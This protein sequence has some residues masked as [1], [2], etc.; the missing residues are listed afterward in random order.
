[1]AV[2]EA[3]KNFADN[4]SDESEFTVDDFINMCIYGYLTIAQKM[5]ARK[6][7]EITNDTIDHII[8]ELCI[9]ATINQEMFDWLRSIQHPMY[10]T[11]KD[12]ISSL[13]SIRY[14]IIHGHIETVNWLNEG[15][16]NMY[17]ELQSLR[18]ME[19]ISV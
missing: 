17:K 1:M 12:C 6:S 5:Y 14:A 2:P 9:R 16:N 18:Q 7:Y 4:Y 10:R 13:L 15:Y 19:S 3:I 11:L 8:T